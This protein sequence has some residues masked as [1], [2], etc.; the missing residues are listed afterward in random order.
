MP[1]ITFRT[2]DGN[3]QHVAAETGDS[4]MQAAI[5]NDVPGIIAECGGSC[6]CSTCHVVVDREWAATVGPPGDDE[7]LTM[8]FAPE[9]GEHSRL[10][11]QIAVTDELDGLVVHVPSTQA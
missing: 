8:E 2:A 1:K 5:A 7:D 6:I 9:R 4:V 11:C 3:E 10:A